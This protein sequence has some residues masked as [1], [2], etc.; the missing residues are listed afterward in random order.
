MQQMAEAL[1]N[2]D[3]QQTQQDMQKMAEA[4]KSGK[5]SKAEIQQ[6]AEWLKSGRMTLAMGKAGQGGNMPGTGFN[7]TGHLTSPMKDP[8]STSPRKI[9]EGKS[10]EGKG[11]GKTKS[12]EEFA[13]YAA[14]KN[15]PSK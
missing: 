6:L 5:M 11:I 14:M 8:S 12:A 2:M 15:P 9:A 1:A 4:L 10:G 7:G 13:K 3:K